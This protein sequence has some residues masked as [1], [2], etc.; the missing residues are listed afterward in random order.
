VRVKAG[1]KL[2]L[3]IVAE[4]ADGDPLAATASGLPA[5]A[6]FAPALLRLS[7]TPTA[8]QAGDHV[9]I[10]H[11]S[12]GTKEATRAIVLEVIQNHAP[13][14]FQRA[15]SLGVGQFG[16]LV[17]GADDSDDDEL[18]YHLANLPAGASFDP[19]RGVLQWRPARG[20]VGKHRF[21][22]SVSDGMAQTEAEFEVEV[23]PASEDAWATFLQPGVGASGYFP[24][25]PDAGS[26][27][28]GS[29]RVSLLSWIHRSETPGPGYGRIYFG[30]ELLA[31][32]ESEL[33]ALFSY[34]VGF[35]VS[36]ERNP[37]RRVLIPMY[38]LELG[39]LVHDELGSPFQLTPFA[40][41]ELFGDADISLSAR[42]GYRVVPARFERLSGA[43]IG[44]SLDAHLW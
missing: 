16:H 36:I 40:G 25:D 18:S 12:D 1:A 10:V 5:G 3:W 7:W 38:G 13:I 8:A 15:Y 42:G 24:R 17:F 26:F 11:V 43:H 9:V 30:G 44:L 19:V 33:S 14:F 4:D 41:L 2:E 32:S 35:E 37:T 6:T 22:V 23:S 29:F 28:G 31:S 27:Y 21:R 34:G 39:G 20:A